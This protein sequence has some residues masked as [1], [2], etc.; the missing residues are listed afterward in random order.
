MTDD[1]PPNPSDDEVIAALRIAAAAGLGQS[2]PAE[3]DL[4]KYDYDLQGVCELIAECTVDEIHKHELDDGYPERNYYIVVL[5]VELDDEPQP[6]YVKVALDLPEM[7][8]GRLLS[9]KYWN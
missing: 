3:N 4:Q 6:F 9:F 1:S 8:T 7:K 2:R 5:N